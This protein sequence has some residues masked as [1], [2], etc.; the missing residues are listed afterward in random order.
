M[1][2]F[3]FIA[4]TIQAL[5]F[6]GLIETE[7][8]D[9]QSKSYRRSHAALDFV[10]DVLRGHRIEQVGPEKLWL[11]EKLCLELRGETLVAGSREFYLGEGGGAHF[12][13]SAENHLGVHLWA[14]EDGGKHRLQASLKMVFHREEHAEGS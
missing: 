7:A 6:I 11:S 1:A 8:S 13:R 5:E 14:H 2:I 9:A 4:W 3:V 12:F 10:K